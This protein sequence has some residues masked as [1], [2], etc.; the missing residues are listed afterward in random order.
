MIKKKIIAAIETIIFTMIFI[1]QF[2]IMSQANTKYISESNVIISYTEEYQENISN[3]TILDDI[4]FDAEFQKWLFNYCDE[5]SMDPYLVLAICQ[6]ESNFIS[7]IVGDSG[8]S[9]GLMQ[10]QLRYNEERMNKLE[11]SNLLN[12]Q[13]NIIVGIDILKDLFETENSIEW[14]LMAY[15]GG[16]RYANK[17]TQKGIISNYA[18][19]VIE[20]YNI[21]INER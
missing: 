20:R 18:C 17:L 5:N 4:P 6:Q 21:L 11:C 15:N 2:P 12:P 3:Y 10:I 19:E 7:D 1:L 8:R 16:N 9:Y 14:V 13:E